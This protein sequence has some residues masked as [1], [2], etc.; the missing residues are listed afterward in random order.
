MDMLKWSSEHGAP[1]CIRRIQTWTSSIVVENE[2]CGKKKV[3]SF[4]RF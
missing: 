2:M 4:I 1:I 3:N